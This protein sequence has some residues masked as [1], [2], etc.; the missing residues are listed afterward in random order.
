[1]CCAP[2]LRPGK[3]NAAAANEKEK[4]RITIAPPCL[5]LVWHRQ[6]KRLDLRKGKSS[7]MV[8]FLD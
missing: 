5:W 6:K 1:L 7:G 3:N 8:L 2:G 4:V